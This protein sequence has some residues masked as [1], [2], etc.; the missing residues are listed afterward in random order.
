MQTAIVKKVLLH[1][2]PIV[3]ANF[4][5]TMRQTSAATAIGTL[6]PRVQQLQVSSGREGGSCCIAAASA[7]MERTVFAVDDAVEAK[8]SRMV[9]LWR[10]VICVVWP[11]ERCCIRF[12]AGQAHTLNRCL[13]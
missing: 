7:S 6:A 9:G 11:K 3:I 2:L 1:S 5:S 12:E 10:L 8:C 4:Q 13:S